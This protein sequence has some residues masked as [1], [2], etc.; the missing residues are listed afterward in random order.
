VNEKREK[1]QQSVL[2]FATKLQVFNF[3]YLRKRI[4]VDVFTWDATNLPLEDQSVDVFVTDL[5]G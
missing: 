5:V 1:K 2:Y 4:L 3:F